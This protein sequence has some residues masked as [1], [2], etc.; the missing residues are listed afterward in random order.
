[1]S[2][3]IAVYCSSSS[4]IAPEFQAAAREL[5]RL[6]GER[7]H[8]LVYGGCHV[9]LMGEIARAVHDH[10]G[11]VCGVIPESIHARGLAYERCEELLVTPDMRERK[12]AMEE[13]ADAF[14]ALPGGFGTLEEVLQAVTLKVLQY[15][16]K[17]IVLINVKGFYDKLLAFFEHLYAAGF[18]HAELRGLYTVVGTTE[19]AM[20]HVES[21]RP[22]EAPATWLSTQ[23]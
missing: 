14:V 19:E 12:A 18:A 6:I 16:S 5:G 2:L 13:R 10:G 1:M 7:G 15:H 20:K 17:P 3:A 21:H 22:A 9:G 23:G 4:Q 11:T 8:S